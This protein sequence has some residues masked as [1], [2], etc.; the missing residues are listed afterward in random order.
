MTYQI[1][2]QKSKLR[3]GWP[4]SPQH[5]LKATDLNEY[6]LGEH[7]TPAGIAENVSRRTGAHCYTRAALL[8]KSALLMLIM[9]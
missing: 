5:G 3:I 9:L 7:G 6:V 8:H 1:I 2:T 4:E